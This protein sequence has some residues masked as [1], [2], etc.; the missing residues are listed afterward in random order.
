MG[1]FV[2]THEYVAPEILS[3]EGYAGSVDWWAFGILIYEMVV[4]RT[5]FKGKSQKETLENIIDVTEEVTF[6]ETSPV[7]NEC[8]DLICKLLAK[9]KTQRL[10]NPLSI[11]AHPFFRN[12]AWPRKFLCF[13]FRFVLLGYSVS[14]H[15]AQLFATK[16][17][18][19]SR[20]LSIL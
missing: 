11:K 1:S 16:S 7:G 15:V 3:E 19:S 8:K 14:V 9:D 6:P 10:Q 4:G 2:G 12:V 5:P 13:P 17:L 18:Q 20:H